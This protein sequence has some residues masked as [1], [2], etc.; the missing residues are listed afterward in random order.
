M[1]PVLAAYIKAEF[2]GQPEAFLQMVED[3]L[4]AE[5]RSRWKGRLLVLDYRKDTGHVTVG[6]TY[7]EA[8]E[9]TLPWD[10]FR[11][12]AARC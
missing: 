7:A 2:S 12:Y 4:F 10:E 9:E 1:T 11:T 3:R 8:V 6:D 5:R